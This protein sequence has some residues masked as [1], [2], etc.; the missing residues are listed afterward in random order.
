MTAI[1]KPYGTCLKNDAVF[2]NNSC[3]QG[4]YTANWKASSMNRK[5][6][7]NRKVTFKEVKGPCKECWVCTYISF[8]KLQRSTTSR[9]TTT[10]RVTCS[11]C[12]C[13]VCTCVA[14]MPP[15]C[16]GLST[17]AVHLVMLRSYSSFTHSFLPFS[18]SSRSVWLSSCSPAAYSTLCTTAH[19]VPLPAETLWA[20]PWIF[21]QYIQPDPGGL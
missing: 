4:R 10:V 1:I 14:Q 16:E 18:G 6:S 11:Y 5:V 8:W 2:Q 20:T 9:R 12:S 7:G 3:L 15:G 17:P 13:S 21:F 19:V